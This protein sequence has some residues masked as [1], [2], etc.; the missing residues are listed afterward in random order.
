MTLEEILRR[1]RRRLPGYSRAT[2]YLDAR[3]L[4]LEPLGEFRTRPQRWP[5]TTPTL[6]LRS[7]NIPQLQTA[8]PRPLS[9]D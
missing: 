9:H 4:Q 3:R 1:I 6:I 7:R 8:T 5:D 2:F